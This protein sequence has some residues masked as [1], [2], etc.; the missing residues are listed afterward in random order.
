[1]MH[2]YNNSYLRITKQWYSVEN[3]T[4]DLVL[5]KCNRATAN[6]TNWLRANRRAVTSYS[7]PFG[8][9]TAY[10]PYSKY[11]YMY[12]QVY[13]ISSTCSLVNRGVFDGTRQTQNKNTS[14]SNIYI[15]YI[16]FR[17]AQNGDNKSIALIPCVIKIKLNHLEEKNLFLSIFF[18]FFK[19]TC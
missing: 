9:P 16:L 17:I 4:V 10:A 14:M 8:Q 1:M 12:V 15:L 11:I 13:C 2:M 18:S 5:E 7:N 19:L 3:T 6:R